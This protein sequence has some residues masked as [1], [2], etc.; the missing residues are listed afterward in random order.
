MH[1]P[2]PVH[3]H[4]AYASLGYGPGAFPEAEAACDSILSLPIYPHLTEAQAAYVIEQVSAFFG[5]STRAAAAT[6][7]RSRTD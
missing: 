5:E 6:A 2:V 7:G 1:Y 3:L 4:P